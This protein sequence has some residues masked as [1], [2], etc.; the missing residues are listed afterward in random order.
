MTNQHQN[1][2]YKILK[3]FSKFISFQSVSTDHKRFDEILKTVEFIKKE[4]IDIGFQVKILKKAIVPPLIIA[5][6]NFCTDRGKNCK[7]IGIYAHYDVQPED[8]LD[9]WNTP[10]FE[11]TIK[12]NKFYGRGVADDKGHIIQILT[13]IKRLIEVNKL[14]NNIIL[15]FEGEEETGSTHFEELI[16]KVKRELGKIDVFY[17]LDFGV[18][19]KNCGKILFGLRGLIGFELTVQ[20]AKTDLHSGIFGNMVNN[21]VQIIAELL[22]KIKNNQTGKILIPSFY[23]KIKKPTKNELFYLE[24]AKKN[25]RDLLTKIFPSFDVNGII[26]GY[27]KEGIKTIIPASATVKFSFRLIEE[28]NPNEIE[29][30]V[31]TFVKKN[32]STGIKYSLR[33]LAKLMPF[34]TDIDDSYIKKSADIFKQVFDDVVFTRTGGSVGAASTLR[35][36]FKKPVVMTGFVLEDANIHS[37]NENYDEEMFFKGIIALEKIFAQ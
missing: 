9:Q 24:K 35:K 36:L 12:D 14:K 31:L 4:L 23:K 21:P 16:S 28:Q 10:P 18:K 30:I 13:S 25:N 2:N 15:I 20:T 22:I 3:L 1:S 37:P 19:D 32:L 27:T 8:P 5:S 29:K 17:L 33:T 7:T 34:Y 26:S 11:L 6:Y